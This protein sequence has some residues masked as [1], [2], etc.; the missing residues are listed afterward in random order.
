MSREMYEV[1]VHDHCGRMVGG[2]VNN[3]CEGLLSVKHTWT[4]ITPRPIGKT[5]AV[6]LADAQEFHSVVCVWM[7]SDKIHDNGKPAR[8]PAGA[9]QPSA[10]SAMAPKATVDEPVRLAQM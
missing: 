10:R 4:R 5:R 1:A 9:W 8:V 3:P 7:S 6:A 2:G